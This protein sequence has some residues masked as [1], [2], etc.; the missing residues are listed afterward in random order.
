MES[1]TK[2]PGTAG[3]TYDTFPDWVSLPPILPT[4]A[5]VE[6]WLPS[7]EI[8]QPYLSCCRI[9]SSTT[10]ATFQSDAAHKVGRTLGMEVKSY[11]LDV[12]LAPGVQ[13]DAKYLWT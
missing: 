9:P 2:F 3:R 7:S 4:D 12:L 11:G 10:V 13:H 5:P 1:D 8:R 6:K